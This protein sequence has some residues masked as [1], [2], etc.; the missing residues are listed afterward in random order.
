MERRHGAFFL[1]LA[2]CAEREWQGPGQR[3]WLARLDQEGD[4]LR[5]AL[6]WARVSGETELGLRLAGAL[7][8]FWR[9]HGYLS[10]GRYWLEGL[11]GEGGP[12][13][14][15]RARAL[16]GAGA[17]ARD[18]GD[19]VHAA[20]RLWESLTMARAVGDREGT[21][22]AMSTLGTVVKLQGD[23][24]HARSLSEESLVLC[25]EDGNSYDAA[26]ALDNLGNIAM[27]EGDFGQ[28]IALHQESLALRRELGDLHGVGV[29]LNNMAIVAYQQG[30]HTQSAAWLEESLAIDR[31]LG[32]KEGLAT[33]LG[34]LGSLLLDM[35]E[36]ERALLLFAEGL[37]LKRDV[38]D[39][40]G[41]A[42]NLFHLAQASRHRGRMARA[43]RLLGAA[44]AQWSSTGV[45]L[46]QGYQAEVA[47]TA[48]AVREALGDAEFA[49]AW[50]TGQAMTIERAIAFARQDAP[51]IPR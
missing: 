47:R 11:L 49:A 36:I 29:A 31:E 2:E 50:A 41:I 6:G 45:L 9:T 8:R 27:R 3:A 43:A 32:D 7:W 17:L 40:D 44:E 20:G 38:G 51:G 33:S 12:A 10:E 35:G 26:I 15:T 23:L 19:L 46:P 25:R 4:N 39:K 13:S 28:S 1:N 37:I 48:A 24:Q 22:A 18:Q 16:L 14:T 21:A 34:N 5:A 30:N 42:Y